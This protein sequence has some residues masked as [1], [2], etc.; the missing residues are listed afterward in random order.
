M[1]QRLRK[2]EETVRDIEQMFWDVM[3]ECESGVAEEHI[4]EEN[5]FQVYV[6]HLFTLIIILHQPAINS[7]NIHQ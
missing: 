3:Q 1:K 7:N 4:E 5:S 2:I 6:L